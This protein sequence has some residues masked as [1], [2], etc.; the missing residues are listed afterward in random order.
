MRLAWTATTLLTSPLLACAPVIIWFFWTGVVHNRQ[1]PLSS[2]VICELLRDFAGNAESV[3]TVQWLIHWLG[4]VSAVMHL[5]AKESPVAHKRCHT[6]LHLLH[7]YSG[8]LF[9]F[10]PQLRYG[11]RSANPCLHHLGSFGAPVCIV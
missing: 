8:W 1:I 5:A 4:V 6:H 2:P 3:L 11:A 7:V 10:L 9:Q